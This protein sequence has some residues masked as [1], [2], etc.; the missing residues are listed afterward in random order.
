MS[1][2]R[3]LLF[4]KAL[5][6]LVCHKTH[7]NFH[8]NEPLCLALLCFKTCGKDPRNYWLLTFGGLL[9]DGTLHGNRKGLFISVDSAPFGNAINNWPFAAVAVAKLHFSA[10]FDIPFLLY[11]TFTF[12]ISYFLESS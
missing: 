10:L 5:L 7:C 4:D 3:H 12:Y 9:P 11:S 2:W 6:I 8:Y 1:T